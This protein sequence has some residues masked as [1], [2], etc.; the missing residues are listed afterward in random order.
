[1][2]SQ[3]NGSDAPVS[4]AAAVPAPVRDS[5]AGSGRVDLDITATVLL[6]LERRLEYRT[7]VAA[8][9]AASAPCPEPPRVSCRLAGLSLAVFG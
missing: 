9:N 6:H 7:R 2:A 1:M 4:V 8:V 3:S 5:T